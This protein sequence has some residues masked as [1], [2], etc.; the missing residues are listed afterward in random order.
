MIFSNLSGTTSDEFKIGSGGNGKVIS[1]NAY[2]IFW[3]GNAD[4]TQQNINVKLIPNGTDLNTMKTIGQYYVI[5]NTDAPTLINCPT[6][7]AFIMTIE[8]SIGI[9]YSNKLYVVQKITDFNG[10]IYCR[11]YDGNG[12][13]WGGWTRTLPNLDINSLA[14]KSELPTIES[15]TIIPDTQDGYGLTNSN[16]SYTLYKYSNKTICEICGV[17]NITINSPT[18]NYSIMPL[19]V[20]VGAFPYIGSCEIYSPYPMTPPAN[21]EYV[22]AYCRTENNLASPALSIYLGGFNTSTK[23][24]G[25]WGFGNFFNGTGKMC[26]IIFNVRIGV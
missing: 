19:P 23:A 20:A 5:N 12:D 1:R 22:G 9:T 10:I 24:Y 13:A 17:V 14:L 4:D 15:G 16:I 21:M 7:R 11:G 18:T 26:N 25:M 6:N 2:D 3:R 8:P